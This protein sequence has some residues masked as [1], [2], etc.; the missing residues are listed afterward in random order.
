[1][2][3]F[4]PVSRMTLT[5]KQMTFKNVWMTQLPEDAIGE[6]KQRNQ[7]HRLDCIRQSHQRFS[8]SN[9]LQEQKQAEPSVT[10]R[11]S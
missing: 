6:D 7:S 1:M 10:N 11:N 4:L 9:L 3:I 5:P 2:V 8:T